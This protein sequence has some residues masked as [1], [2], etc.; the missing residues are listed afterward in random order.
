MA[1]ISLSGHSPTSVHISTPLSGMA[2]FPEGLASAGGYPKTGAWVPDIL[3]TALP[4]TL[5]PEYIFLPVFVF[6]EPFP[7]S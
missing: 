2:L 1:P 7:T 6:L 3:K 5:H 4:L